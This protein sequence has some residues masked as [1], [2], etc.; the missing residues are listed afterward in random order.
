MPRCWRTIGALLGVLAGLAACGPGATAPPASGPAPAAPGAAAAAPPAREPIKVTYPSEGLGGIQIIAARDRGF[1]ERNGFAAE[2]VLLGSD[3]AVAAVASG[4]IHYLG[5]VG[6]ASIAATALGLPLRAVMIA[7]SSPAYTVFARPD[8]RTLDDLRGKRLGLST[9]GGTATVALT[10]ALKRVGI[11]PA[12]DLITQQLAGTD[13]LRLEALRAG[14]I[15]AAAL[16]APHSL[17]ARREGYT[18]VLDV[19]SL[20]QMPVG[21]LSVTLAKLQGEPEQVRRA[22][23]ALVETQ[24]WFITSREEAIQM[25][26]DVLQTDRATAEGTYEEALPTYQT[27]GLVS[28]EG[29]DNILDALRAE[30]RIPPDV[31][32]EDVADGRIA[33]AVARELGLLP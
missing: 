5:G 4:E 3:R 1:F 14:A 24:Q 16:S 28:R 30:G 33:E 18:P 17:L 22:V 19:A 9:V 27:K 13:A 2:T 29:I 26:M 32:Y 21:G 11:D 23:R 10:L 25:M 15:D 8:I 6:P 31:R 12:H 7:T 20:V